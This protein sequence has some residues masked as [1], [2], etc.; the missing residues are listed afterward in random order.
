MIR[1]RRFVATLAVAFGAIVLAS[2]CVPATEQQEIT[3]NLV[4]GD[5]TNHG[6]RTLAFDNE[7]N[8]KAQA[9]SEHLARRG[10]LAHSRL[11]DGYTNGSWCV[12]AENVGMASGV[13]QSVAI[14]MIQSGFMQ[15][16]AHRANILTS[17]FTHIGTGVTTTPNG[18]TFVVQEFVK[19][20]PC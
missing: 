11:Q 4:N 20:K 19:R 13:P 5:R 17:G 10:S 18:T 1:T 14:F 12:L 7:A 9:W 16:P 3:R 15:S 2:G 8:V 6:L